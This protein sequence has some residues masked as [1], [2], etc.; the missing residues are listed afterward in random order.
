MFNFE[1]TREP[2]ERIPVGHCKRCDDPLYN[3]DEV[4]KQDGYICKNCKKAESFKAATPSDFKEFIE[5]H[6]MEDE[7]AEWYYPDITVL[8]T[9]DYE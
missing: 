2:E 6:D 7:F 8:E 9:E 4:V 5:N 3:G 1:D